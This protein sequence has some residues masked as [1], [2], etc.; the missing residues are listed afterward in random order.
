MVGVFKCKIFYFKSVI[1]SLLLLLPF[2]LIN[3]NV[4]HR[5]LLLFILYFANVGGSFLRR[6]SDSDGIQSG[7]K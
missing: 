1:L 7:R 2:F 5:G 3:V 4:K 6:G